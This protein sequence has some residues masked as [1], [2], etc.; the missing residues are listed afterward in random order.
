MGKIIFGSPWKCLGGYFFRWTGF[1]IEPQLF[2]IGSPNES[3][4]VL[5]TCNFIITV[6]R[7]IKALNGV[8]C[9]LLIAPSKG[10][11]VWCGAC[12]DDFT[13]DS[14]ISILKTSGI[15]QK[16]SHRTVILPQLSATGLDPVVIKEKTGWTA[17]F[18]PVYAKDIPDYLANETKKTQEQR[19]VTFPVKDRIEMGSFYFF[20]AFIILSAFFWITSIFLDRL[21]WKL[22]LDTLMMIILMIYGPLLVAPIIKFNTGKQKNLLFEVGILVLLGIIHLVLVYNLFLFF[23]NAGFSIVLGLLMG[24]DLHGLTPIYKSELGEATWNKGKETMDFL[25]MK[26]KLNPYGTISLH[27]ELCIGCGMCVDICPQGLY[28]MD[29]Q[30]HKIVLHSPEKCVNCNA[31]VRRCPENC[32]EILPNKPKTS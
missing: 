19:I 27:R 18:G 12:G 4:P 5:L 24:E 9:W 11:N 29:A 23:W 13:S 14:A 28:Q 25:G 15:E 30:D 6:K 22:Y 31:C 20:T 32:L 10:I 17:K 1:P 2:K 21:D 16:V 7:V 3:S 8:D 26:I